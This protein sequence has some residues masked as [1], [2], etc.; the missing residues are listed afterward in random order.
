MNYLPNAFIIRVVLE[1]QINKEISSKQ[2]VLAYFIL[3]RYIR[4]RLFFFKRYIFS[5]DKRIRSFTGEN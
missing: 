1:N 4:G 5:D 3:R 2:I